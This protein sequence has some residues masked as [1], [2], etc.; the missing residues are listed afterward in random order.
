MADPFQQY[1]YPYRNDL[2]PFVDGML[3]ILGFMPY[4]WTTIDKEIMDIRQTKSRLRACQDKEHDIRGCLERKYF[5]NEEDR[6]R[7]RAVLRAWLATDDRYLDSQQV[8]SHSRKPGSARWTLPLAENA[9]GDRMVRHIRHELS[10]ERWAFGADIPKD[11]TL[12]RYCTS[13]LQWHFEHVHSLIDE[14]VSRVGMQA[15]DS[16][17]H[18]AGKNG[19]DRLPAVFRAEIDDRTLKQL[20][21]TDWA[22]SNVLYVA[23][24]NW[25]S[26]N[27]QLPIYT[28]YGL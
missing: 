9:V 20:A 14:I 11:M 4:S 25:I 16:A 28:E 27:R 2:I 1:L 15:V 24:R 13:L 10:Q 6:K 22:S 5:P 18:V 23:A 21:S 19:R 12:N 8:R 7:L 17:G 3:F 26:Q